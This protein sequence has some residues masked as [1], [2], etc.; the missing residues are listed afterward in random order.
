MQ[1]STANPKEF[2]ALFCCAYSVNMLNNT[3]NYAVDSAESSGN[4]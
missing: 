3:I 2:T 4:L 1:N